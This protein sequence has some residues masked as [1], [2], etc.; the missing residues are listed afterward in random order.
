MVVQECGRSIHQ[1]MANK[2]FTTVI[3]IMCSINLIP[4][5]FAPGGALD[6]WTEEVLMYQDTACEQTKVVSGIF[7]DNVYYSLNFILYV[8]LG[9]FTPFISKSMPRIVKAVSILMGSW[10]MAMLVTEMI[11]FTRPTEV[12]NNPN[13]PVIYLKVTIAFIISVI[14]LVILN[15][16]NQAHSETS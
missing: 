12:L 1:A 14:F 3:I 8:V 9:L 13:E 15:K 6:F 10:F 5:L 2:I 7:F 11:N 4:P 16:W